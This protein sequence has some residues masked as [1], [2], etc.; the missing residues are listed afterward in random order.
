MAHGGSLPVEKEVEERRKLYDLAKQS[1]ERWKSDNATWDE[2][3]KYLSKR[4]EHS[5]GQVR[6]FQGE[7]KTRDFKLVK[8]RTKIRQA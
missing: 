8:L 5:E 6:S 3:K 7:A 4:L 2:E 1:D